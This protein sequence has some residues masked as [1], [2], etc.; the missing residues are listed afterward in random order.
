LLGLSGLLLL[1]ALYYCFCKS[2]YPSYYNQGGAA[3]VTPAGTVGGAQNF[4]GAQNYNGAPGAQNFGGA[5]GAQNYGGMTGSQMYGG[6][7]GVQN[8][9]GALG[10]QNFGGVTGAQNFGAYGNQGMPL[11]GQPGFAGNMVQGGAFG[12]P[13]INPAFARSGRF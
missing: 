6:A 1:F 12:G 8:Y 13:N 7:P 10:G 11:P 2:R 9:G 4:G 5:P 3:Q